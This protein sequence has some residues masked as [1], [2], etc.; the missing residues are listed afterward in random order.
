MNRGRKEITGAQAYDKGTCKK[1]KRQDIEGEKDA[2]APPV[3]LPR[4]LEEVTRVS[5][6]L[7]PCAF[8]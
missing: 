4:P 3:Y 8:R 5:E 7:V 6:I 1:E 2:R